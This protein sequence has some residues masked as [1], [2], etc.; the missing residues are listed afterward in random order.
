MSCSAW[1][2]SLVCARARKFVEMLLWTVQ[3]FRAVTSSERPFQL[4]LPAVLTGFTFFVRPFCLPSL[5][6]GSSTAPAQAWVSL[7]VEG[8]AGFCL[9]VRVIPARCLA[10]LV[11]WHRGPRGQALTQRRD[12]G[13]FLVL[14]LSCSWISFWAGS[15]WTCLQLLGLCEVGVSEQEGVN[16]AAMAWNGSV[17]YAQVLSP[18]FSSQG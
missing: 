10:P 1:V 17:S 3:C 14:F 8:D 9:S 13:L 2:Y 5:G 11:C 7:Q 18:S 4:T 16:C 6:T 15:L 12:R